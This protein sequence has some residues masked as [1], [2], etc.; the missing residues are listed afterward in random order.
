MI[1]NGVQLLMFPK[2]PSVTICCPLVPEKN[3][4]EFLQCDIVIG[5]QNC[6]NKSHP[7]TAGRSQL[8]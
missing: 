1:D 4:Y 8:Y 5:A 3:V 6:S 2:Q 7:D